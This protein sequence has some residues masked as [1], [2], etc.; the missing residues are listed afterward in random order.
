LPSRRRSPQS[1]ASTTSCIANTIA[2][3][4]GG[5]SLSA[6]ATKGS[7]LRIGTM[8]TRNIDTGR[9]VGRPV[10]VALTRE[11]RSLVEKLAV[12]EQ[13][14][15]HGLRADPDR[16]QLEPNAGFALICALSGTI[17]WRVSFRPYFMRRFGMRQKNPCKPWG[18]GNV[19]V[20]TLP[21]PIA[22][23]ELAR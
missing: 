14:D 1:S 11:G 16:D 17:C 19:R 3:W 23:T 15:D 2:P 12:R 9:M 18:R 5:S 8:P 13:P 22:P 21:H 20:A 10:E 7:T 6:G 4:P